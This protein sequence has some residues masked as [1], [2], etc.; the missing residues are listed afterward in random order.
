MK[1]LTQKSGN[2]LAILAGALLT[3]AFAPFSYYPLAIIAPALLLGTWLSVTPKQALWRGWLFGLGFFGT[4]VYWV[5]ISI[6]T[7]G[8]AS[9]PLALIITAVFIAILAIF[10]ALNGYLLNRIFPRDNS[11]KL[12][13]GFPI[14]WV[15]FEWIRSWIFTGFPWLLLGYSQI[16][17]PLRGYAPIFSVYGISLAALIC[18]GLLIFSLLNK[19]IL[20]LIL[21]FGIFLLGF[22]LNLIVWTQPYKKVQVTLVQ[23]NI[24]QDL[25][26][27]YEQVLPTLDLYRNLSKDHWNSQIVIWPEAAIPI[28]LDDAM[29]YVHE[30]SKTAKKNHS[31]LITGIPLKDDAKNAY[32]N[33]VI[34]LGEG[35]GLYLKHRLVPFGEYIPL[36]KI[37]DPV[38]KDILNIPLPDSIPAKQ[39]DDYLV[40]DGLKIA[41]FIC[42]EIAFPLQVRFTDENINM[43]L[44]VSNDA[45][46]GDSIAQPQHLEMGQMRAIE[47]GRPVLFVSNNGITAIINADGKIQARAPQFVQTTLTGQVQT[48]TGKTP[49]QRFSLGLLL[50]IMVTLLA[51]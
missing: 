18:S 4:G 40:A 9:T 29:E 46:F 19:K 33:G 26:W 49:W 51:A 2:F 34:A 42:Y 11:T 10:P 50:I 35:S 41:T 45:W 28:V 3:L 30:M 38:F 1:F 21:I 22:C 47:L 36:K 7:Y 13:C 12:L 17:S 5:F 44:T 8:N 24:P 23:G 39:S 43:I 32:Y 48:T 31:A 15:I 20:Y 25:K 16:N 6:H 37:F 14:L 27:T